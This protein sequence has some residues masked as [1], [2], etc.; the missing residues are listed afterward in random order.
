MIEDAKTEHANIEKGATSA[1]DRTRMPHRPAAKQDAQG[2]EV[3]HDASRMNLEIACD[4][5][6]DG[7][8]VHREPTTIHLENERISRIEPGV[9]EAPSRTRIDARGALV[10]PGLINAHVHV[11]RGGMFEPN[12][13]PGVAQPIANLEGSIAAGV[14]TIGDMGC[15]PAL[16]DALRSRT[17]RD[18]SAGPSIVASG[19]VLTAPHGYPLDWMPPLFKRLGV[20]LGCATERDAAR[21]VERVARAKMDHVKLAIMHTSYADRPLEAVTLPV[22][23][24]IV[25]EAHRLGKRVLAHAHG[26]ADYELALAAGVDALLHSSFEPIDASMVARIRDAGIPVCPTLWVFES[27]CLGAEMRFD[28]DPRFVDRVT[29]SIARSW[30]R[31]VEAWNESGDVVP[32]GIAGGAN[33]ARAKDAVRIAAANLKLLR[34]AGVPI[35]FGNDANYGFSLVARPVDELATMQR[36]GLS[37]VECLRAA[38]S[39]AASLLA[40]TDRGSS[41]PGKRGDFAIVDARAIDDVAHVES[42]RA[43]VHAGRLVDAPSLRARVGTGAAFVRGLGR[44]LFDGLRALA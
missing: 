4:L 21:A 43:V 2:A 13:P 38:T 30:R 11:A 7:E 17:A 41:S 31:F 27:A 26:V 23:R 9:S 22:A 20:A 14:T 24:A 44:T 18:R 19:P 39:A 34:D 8:R 1:R 10:L 16:I 29:P 35:A 5:W 28:R 40:L 25:A 32:P 36:A 37:A 6:F 42:V 12:E 3:W 15:A 33:K